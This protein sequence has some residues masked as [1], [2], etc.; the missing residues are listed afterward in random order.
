[1]QQSMPFMF[2]LVWS[3]HLTS[4]LFS[5]WLAQAP[6][7]IFT[8]LGH[9]NSSCWWSQLLQENFEEKL[10]LRPVYFNHESDIALQFTANTS[11]CSRHVFTPFCSCLFVCW[12]EVHVYV[13]YSKVFFKFKW[14]FK[15]CFQFFSLHPTKCSTGPASWKTTW[16]WV[17]HL[18]AKGLP[19]CCWWWEASNSWNSIQCHHTLLN[20]CG[21]RGIFSLVTRVP[22]QSS[23]TKLPKVRGCE[24]LALRLL[25]QNNTHQVLQKDCIKPCWG[26][27][28]RYLNWNSFFLWNVFGLMK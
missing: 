7:A 6:G 26:I 2:Q 16:L 17:A 20:T 11:Y 19:V 22:I 24:A 1:M 27:Q 18:W 12:S 23:W 10:V 5:V 15:T 21:I 3:N 13:I 14:S 8:C 9:S 28:Y 25:N 4:R